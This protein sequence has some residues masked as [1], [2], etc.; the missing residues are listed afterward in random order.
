MSDDE[1]PGPRRGIVGGVETESSGRRGLAGPSGRADGA[2]PA[3]VLPRPSRMALSG[4]HFSAE[5]LPDDWSSPLPRRSATS[6]SEWSPAT[7]LSPAEPAAHPGTASVSAVGRLAASP[8][9]VR[10]AAVPAA[11]GPRVTPAPRRGARSV[12]IA[13]VVA[14]V[15]LG[16]LAL[17]WFVAGRP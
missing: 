11:V 1:R 16:A 12:A 14:G 5:N 4:R 9:D 3:P 2:P 10:G 13:V 15:L 7:P 6:P 17:A 8:A